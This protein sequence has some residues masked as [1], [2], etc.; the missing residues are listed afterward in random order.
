[1]NCVC[2]TVRW[3]LTDELQF[4]REILFEILIMYAFKYRQ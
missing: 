3:N 4:Q 1:M 2:M